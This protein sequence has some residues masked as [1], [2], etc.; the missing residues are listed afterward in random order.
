MMTDFGAIRP[1]VRI[2]YT[3]GQMVLC[4]FTGVVG[5]EFKMQ[6]ECAV[7]GH[8]CSVCDLPRF[9]GVQDTLKSGKEEVGP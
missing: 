3:L 2:I 6:Q 5:R 1:V 7:A 9:P 4:C 8:S